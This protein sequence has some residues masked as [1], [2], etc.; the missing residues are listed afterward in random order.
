MEV[1]HP[2]HS[3]HYKEMDDLFIGVFNVIPGRVSWDLW[4]RIY[5]NMQ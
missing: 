3:S 2:N 4:R 1:H 5:G